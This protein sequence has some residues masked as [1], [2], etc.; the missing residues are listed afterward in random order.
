MRNA[1]ALLF[2]LVVVVVVFFNIAVFPNLDHQFLMFKEFLIK[3][4]ITQVPISKLS[5]FLRGSIAADSLSKS[6]NTHFLIMKNKLPHYYDVSI[7][8]KAG[9]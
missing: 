5:S 7:L 3:S 4:S 2:L 1:V 8:I 9:F 6:R